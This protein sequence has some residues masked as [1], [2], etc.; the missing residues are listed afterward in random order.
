[1][2]M[3]DRVLAYI[4]KNG[5][6][7]SMQAFKDLGCTRLSQ[8]ILLLRKNGYNIVGITQHSI[9]R[10]GQKVHYY[11]YKLIEDLENE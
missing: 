7:T 9:N 2:K 4:K 10:Y 11:E 6:I 1:M 5:S 8:Y 3:Y